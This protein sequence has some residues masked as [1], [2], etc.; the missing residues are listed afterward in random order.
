MDHRTEL[1]QGAHL[2]FPGMDCVIVKAIGRGSNAIVYEGEYRDA[3]S[4]QRKHRVLIKELFPFDPDGHIWRDGQQ[5]ICRDDQGETVW[6]LHRRSFERGNSIHLQLLTE[7]PDQ[8]GGN[9]NTFALNQTLY[10]LLDYS[11]GRSLDKA[12]H[13]GA[14]Q[15]LPLLLLRLY[16]QTSLPTAAQITPQTP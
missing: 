14:P 4:A 2:A 7:H 15:P 5:R 11:G 13:S 6:S 1:R 12:L 8:T 16:R 3:T 10:T 9:L